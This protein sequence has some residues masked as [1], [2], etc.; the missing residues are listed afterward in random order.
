VRLKIGIAVACALFVAVAH[1]VGTARAAS[2]HNEATTE[3]LVKFK[4]GAP[5][6]AL[7]ARAGVVRIGKVRK[8]GVDVVRVNAAQRLAAEVSLRASGKVSY[9]ENNDVVKTFGGQM[10]TDPYFYLDSWQYQNPQLPQAWAAGTGSSS[11]VVAVVDTGVTKIGDLAASGVVLPGYNAFNGTSA[12]TDNFGHGTE[13]ASMIAGRANNGIG[14]AGVC[15]SCK[16]LPVKAMDSHGHGTSASI[17]SGITWAADHGAQI[18]NLSLGGPSDDQTEDNA[19]A[20]A[21]SKGIIVI[22]SA[23][24]NGDT[25]PNYPADLPGVI[26]VAASDASDARESFSTYGS[27]VS[28]AAPGCEQLQ[29]MGGG[30]GWVCGTSFAGPLTA[31]IAALAL[32]DVPTMTAAQFTSALTSTAD[33]VPG[34]YVQYGRVNA[35]A[36]LQ[37]LGVSAPDFAIKNTAAPSFSG[38]STIGQTLQISDGTW[39]VPQGATPTYTYQWFRCTAKNSCTAITGATASSYSPTIADHGDNLA[40]VVTAAANGG[41]VPTVS[42]QLAQV[43]TPAPSDTAL[44]TV[45]GTALAGQLLKGSVGTWSLAS[46]YRY[47]WLSCDT[48]GAN[49]ASIAGATG[50]SYAVPK[51]QGGHTLR[52]NVTATGFGG[53][54]AAQ[55]AATATVALPPAPA[56]S[57]NPT[58]TGTSTVSQKLTGTIGAWSVTSGTFTTARQWMRCDAQGA[59]CVAIAKATTP[60]YTLTTSDNGSTIVLE[61]SATGLG[62]T[63]T[64]DSTPTAVVVLPPAPSNTVVPKITGTTTA[65]KTLTVGPGTWTA[66]GGDTIARQWER[67]DAQGANCAAITGATKTSYVL[68]AADAGNTIVVHTTATGLG[69]STSVD[70]AASAVIAAAPAPVNSTTPSITGA[71]SVGKTLTGARGV[72]TNV[73]TY[74]YAWLRCT[75]GAGTSCTAI[76]G[77]TGSTYKLTLA[78]SQSYIVLQVTGVGPGGTLIKT[79]AVTAKIS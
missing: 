51:A 75:D 29:Q 38:S 2:T 39:S 71:T 1:S 22:A 59:N 45:T 37:A 26:S 5:R 35:A 13:V 24:N 8:L 40:A 9:V 6:A 30:W 72:W 20:Y 36:T 55:S 70:S 77:A 34:S 12:S 57:T 28:V 17:S 46:T 61:I 60:T 68:T 7:L 49:C 18:I 33:A 43:T 11:V 41:S 48:S 58:V 31:G 10:P 76:T 16:I 53:S 3:L 54:T 25:T 56:A 73:T 32:S 74:S 63:A 52:L 62:G 21:L 15:W 19:V 23:G 50:T 27:W 42:S 14:I 66:I 4:A 65:G 79:S 44:P 47:Q 67:C 64:A 69:G 78:D